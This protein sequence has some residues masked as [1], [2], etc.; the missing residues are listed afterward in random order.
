MEKCA[1]G[2]R[3]KGIEITGL[4]SVS[5]SCKKV[6]GLWLMSLPPPKKN[7]NVGLVW[8]DDLSR[9]AASISTHHSRSSI[10]SQLIHPGLIS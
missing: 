2:R 4:D 6:Q 7:L 8:V 3:K 5:E 10:R 9:T 1:D